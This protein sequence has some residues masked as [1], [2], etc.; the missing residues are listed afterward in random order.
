MIAGTHYQLDSYEF[1]SHELELRFS[2]RVAAFAC[3]FTSC[4]DPVAGAL[5]AA[6]LA[7]S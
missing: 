5:Q 1:G 3:A 2:A 6:F 7:E 4:S